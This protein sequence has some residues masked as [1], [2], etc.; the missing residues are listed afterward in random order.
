MSALPSL[1]SDP[2]PADLLRLARA[3]ATQ[4]HAETNH[5]YDGQPYAVH[6]QIVFD[7]GR[8]YQ[9]L[10]PADAVPYALA[11]CWTH[12]TIEDCRLTYHDVKAACGEAVAEITYALTNEKGRTRSERANARYYDGIRR[13]PL[14]AFVKV[15][16]RLAN[17]HYSRDHGSRMLDGY[18]RENA[19][20]QAK[21]W[22]A[23]LAP[24]FDELAALLA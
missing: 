24:M 12:D 6:L 13:T 7:F 20:F 1:I 4:A 18:R 19:H 16:D 10:L 9:P 11:A 15:C 14:A 17:A 8:Q 23:E 21:L 5:R 2:A 3:F 22:S